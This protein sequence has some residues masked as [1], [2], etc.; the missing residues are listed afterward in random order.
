M[1]HL[2]YDITKII[3]SYLIITPFVFCM[4]SCNKHEVCGCTPPSGH[5][6][7]ELIAYTW[8]LVSA[9]S[10]NSLSYGTLHN[11]K[12]VSSDSLHFLWSLNPNFNIYATCSFVQQN[13]DSVV[14]SIVSLNPAS[15]FSYSDTSTITYDTLIT[16]TPWRPNYSDTLFITKVSPTLLVF[17]VGYTDAYG[18]GVE[19]D[20]FKN[21]G[22]YR[23]F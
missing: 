5:R 21:V 9:T 20:S 12:G 2:Q 7:N 17:K 15:G 14:S 19:I 1:K 16:S 18:S 10:I 4:Q 6:P 22:S 23:P 3:F 11:Y 13:G 8:R